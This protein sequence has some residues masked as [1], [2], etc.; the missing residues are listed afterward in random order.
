MLRRRMSPWLLLFSLALIPCPLRAL[1]NGIALRPPMGWN[2]WNNFGCNINESLIRATADAMATNGM[3]AAGY[4][5]INMDDCWEVSRDPTGVIVPDPARFPSGIKAL[6]DYVHSKGL[7]L[8]LYSD[9]G[10]Q[11]CGGRPGGYGYE[12]LDAN[13]YGAWGVD[14][15]KYDNCNLPSGDV[16]QT[17]YFHMS[18]ALMRSGRPITFSIC[19]WTFDS[20][21]PDLGNLWRTTGDISDSYS[22]MISK[23]APNSESA[24]VAA[25]GRWNDPDMLEVGRGG[26]STTED[27][28]HFTL[29]CMMAAPLIAGNDLTTMSAQTLAI[30]TN[31]EVIAVDQDP[32]GEQGIQVTGSDTN[33]IWCKPLGFDFS[34]KAVA[35]FNNNS[36]AANITCYWTNLGLQAGSATVRDLWAHTDLGTFTNSFTTNVPPHGTVLLKVAGTAPVLPVIGTN[37]LSDLQSVYAYVGWGAMTKDKSI[38]GN[39]LTLNG[40]TY[41][42]GLGVHAL[43][44]IE[45]RLGAIASQF[46]ADIGVDD[47]AGAGLGSVVFQVFADG[48]KIYD[49]GVLH[50]GSPHQSLN[51][52][53]TGVNRL[54]LGVHDADDN[55]NYDHADW[56]GARVT[57]L[58]AVPS[59]PSAPTGLAANPGNPVGLTWNPTRSASNYIIKRALAAPGPYTNL[60][61]VSLPG[62]GD[63]NVTSGT[64]YFYKV[65][66]GNGFGE[67]ADSVVIGVTACSTP[68]APAGL[69]TGATA[70][71]IMLAWNAAPGATSYNIAR[72]TS[73]TP[74]IPLAAALA[75][76]SFTDTNVVP[77]TTYFYIVAGSNSCNEGTFSPPV[78]ATTAPLAPTGLA[79]VPGGNNAVLTWSPA[80]PATGFNV[81][82]STTNGGPYVIIANNVAA[83][84]WLDGS[85][86]AGTTYYYVVS[87]INAGGESPNSLQASVTPCGGVLPGGWAD[88][89]IGT[90]AFA[91]TASSCASSFVLQ[92]SGA[93]IW[94]TA[95]AFNFASTS[96]SGNGAIVARVVAVQNTDPWAKAGL[97][98][99]NDTTPGSMFADVFVSPANG[100]NFQ[101]R[102]VSGGQCGS[103]S[104]GGVTAPIWVK[105]AR[106]GTNFT[107]AYSSNGVQWTSLGSIG[108]AMNNAARAGLAVTAHNNSTLCLSSFDHVAT[109]VPSAPTSLTAFGGNGWVAL[110]WDSS[111][112]AASYNVKRS[113]ISGGPY[114]VL[115]NQTAT[116]AVDTAVVNWSTWYYVVSSV[117]ALGES[118]NSSEVVATP[119]PPPSLNAGSS[120]GLFQLSWPNWATGYNAYSASNLLPPVQWQLVTNAPQSGGGMFNLLLPTT[121]QQQF[122]QLKGP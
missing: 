11:T 37:Y 89:D 54:T 60:A 9:H 84:P 47:E 5:F 81:K 41:A 102:T 111:P 19:A 96:L 116:S 71:Q 66:A 55:I 90:V 16:P 42:K 72:S 35:L 88:Q 108:I 98:F 25:P 74:F 120:N 62:Y 46:V 6:A 48:M 39:T 106:V 45:Y 122:F 69:T 15:L 113:N 78:L 51:L 91:G 117:N 30:L 109:G 29:W 31:P 14:Y 49:S 56:A 4:Q 26:M 99:R 64:T 82:R 32:A 40:A 2:S 86:T 28:S 73:A 36:N 20:W 95:D 18:D 10:V 63:T 13:T 33:Q 61:G 93:D 101:W 119:R 103:T 83:P 97:M 85:L 50:G 44:G 75:G 80:S 7:K 34:T 12:Y 112:A 94:G 8:G 68:A 77:G 105:L 114:G 100:V 76:T 23:L 118:A 24:Y 65:S 52:D 43:S 38:G 110:N 87:A 21:D 58:S 27:Q 3:K 115:G 57:V 17:D 121:G 70:S 22:S 104:L 67:S 107:A 59:A 92:G 79:A 53:V 1:T